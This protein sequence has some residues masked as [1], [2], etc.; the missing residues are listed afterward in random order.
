MMMRHF[1]TIFVE[2]RH[3]DTKGRSYSPGFEI[4][5]DQM[6]CIYINMLLFIDLLVYGITTV[7]NILSQ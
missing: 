7:I 6:L 1:W 5:K 4:L 2:K 3:I